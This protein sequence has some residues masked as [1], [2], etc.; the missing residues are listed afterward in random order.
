MLLGLVM[1]WASLQQE[2]L[3]Q[4]WGL[5]RRQAELNKIAP[6]EQTMFGVDVTHVQ[7]FEGQWWLRSFEHAPEVRQVD[8]LRVGLLR[9]RV[10]HGG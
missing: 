6:L 7:P 1:E 10:V 2:E 5:A 4:D 3:T 9:C 8:G